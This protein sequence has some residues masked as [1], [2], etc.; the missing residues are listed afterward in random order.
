V[1][2]A[3]DF[4]IAM[5]GAAIKAARLAWLRTYWVSRVVH[6]PGFRLF[7][8]ID[9]DDGTALVSFG[10]NG[11]TAQELQQALLQRFGIFTVAR[12]IGHSEIVRA[13]VAITTRIEELDQ[14][15]AALTTLAA[16]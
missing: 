1:P 6:L 5:G 2:A 4:H 14:F 16:R 12:N 9:A 8:P 7:S 15:V 11:M 13:T 3:L 10:L